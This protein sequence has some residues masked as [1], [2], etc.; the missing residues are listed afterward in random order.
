MGEVPEEQEHKEDDCPQRYEV[1]TL[2]PDIPADSR[3][4]PLVDQSHIAVPMVPGLG[5]DIDVEAIA[6]YPSLGNLH[7]GP[8]T[9]E[10]DYSYVWS[11]TPRA[12]WLAAPKL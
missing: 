5:C 2:H 8:T 9:P 4:G 7:P 1:M 11:Q 3:G 10:L 6:K 12:E